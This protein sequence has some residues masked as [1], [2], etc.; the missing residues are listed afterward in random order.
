MH[1]EYLKNLKN[2]SPHTNFVFHPVNVG[3]RPCFSERSEGSL[4]AKPIERSGSVPDFRRPVFE[5]WSDLVAYHRKNN[6]RIPSRSEFPH[7]HDFLKHDKT[8]VLSDHFLEKKKPKASLDKR[9]PYLAW[10]SCQSLHSPELR[11]VCSCNDWINCSYCRVKRQVKNKNRIKNYLNAVNEE[12]KRKKHLSFQKFKFITLTQKW[13]EGASI[14]EMLDLIQKNFKKLRKRKAW[15]KAI[16][17]DYF[18]ASYEISEEMTNIHV[19]IVALAK[20]WDIKEISKQW[21]DVTKDSFIVDIRAI[22]S[23]DEAV[24]EIAKYIVKDTNPKLVNEMS[25]FRKLNPKRRYLVSGRR[26]LLLDTIAITEHPKCKTC[27]MKMGLHGE[28]K[29]EIAAKAWLISRNATTIGHD[30]TPFKH[31]IVLQ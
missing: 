12:R 10:Y 31:D 14:K 8:S 7:L 19:H 4:S 11:T 26:P 2:N 18:I 6:L 27:E 17:T 21:F 24:E 15:K 25:E 16:P 28:F 30:S 13:K 1:Q 20:F 5:K 3:R 29:D 9:K 23:I 22:T